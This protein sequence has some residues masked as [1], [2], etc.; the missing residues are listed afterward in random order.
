MN[1]SLFQMMIIVAICWIINSINLISWIKLFISIDVLPSFVR[2]FFFHFFFLPFTSWILYFTSFFLPSFLQFFFPSIFFTLLFAFFYFYTFYNLGSLTVIGSPMG[3]AR[4][5]GSGVKSF[6]YEPYQG[7]VLGPQ[8]FVL[9]IGKGT[10]HLIT[11]VV[12]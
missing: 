9:G 10:H 2:C 11:N 8:D 6:F 5:I 4:K 3:F 12:R 1:L 7:A